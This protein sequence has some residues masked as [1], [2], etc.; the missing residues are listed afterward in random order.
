MMNEIKFK[1]LTDLYK[2][3]MPA[4]KSKKSE[5]YL[6]GYKFITELDIWNCLRSYKWN[7]QTSLTLDKMVDDILN[8]KNELFSMYLN[9][10]RKK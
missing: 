1:S 6:C 4:L 7:D 8:T 2:R 3:L 5:L 9:D 10:I